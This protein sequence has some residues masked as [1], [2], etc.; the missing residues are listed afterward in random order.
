MDNK[1]FNINGCTFKQFSLALELLLMGEYNDNIKN[2]NTKSIGKIGSGVTG[3]KFS[4]KKG[5]ILYW[6]NDKKDITSIDEIIYD[7]NKMILTPLGLKT[8]EKSLRTYKLA[9]LDEKIKNRVNIPFDILV[10][11]LW[12]WY[13]NFK[14]WDKLELENW[15]YNIKHDGSNSKGFRIY[16]EDWGRVNDEWYTIGA[17]KPVYLWYGK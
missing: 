9:L 5:L 13:N 11:S 14:E 12:Y 4:Y 6:H 16:T 10:Y 15:D 7:F 1:I 3:Y 2:F 8:L 17:I